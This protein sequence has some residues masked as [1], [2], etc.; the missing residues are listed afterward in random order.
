[1]LA[2]AMPA[3]TRPN[4][5]PGTVAAVAMMI[6]DSARPTQ[7][8]TRTGRRP[9]RSEAAPWIG[10]NTNCISENAVAKVPIARAAAAPLP[11]RMPSTRRGST[12]DAVE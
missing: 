1:M 11:C 7:D 12:G 6:C 4:S 9:N 8:T 2:A 3:S 5:N 10:P